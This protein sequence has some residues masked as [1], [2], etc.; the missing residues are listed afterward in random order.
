MLDAPVILYS[1][2]VEPGNWAPQVY[3]RAWCVQGRKQCDKTGRVGV[4][5]HA[6]QHAVGVVSGGRIKLA[7]ALAG[8]HNS[9]DVFLIPKR[10]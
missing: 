6:L 5:Q 3:R 2:H 9:V 1:Q 4:C 8:I 7:L 10:P